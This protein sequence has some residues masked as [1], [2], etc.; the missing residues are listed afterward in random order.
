MSSQQLVV[1][2]ICREIRECSVVQVEDRS[3]HKPNGCNQKH[4][5]QGLIYS[6]SFISSK[7]L[8]DSGSELPTIQS[9]S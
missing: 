1:D 4:A 3:S 8:E 9:T 6:D 7:Q 2:R 5:E